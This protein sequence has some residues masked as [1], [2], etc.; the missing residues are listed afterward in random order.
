MPAEASGRAA[1]TH[2]SVEI[3]F[4]KM[5]AYLLRD[6]IAVRTGPNEIQYLED[7]LWAE[8]LDKSFQRALIAN[9]S[10]SFPAAEIQ[11]ADF[12][13]REHALEE[14][15]SP[16]P[17]HVGEPEGPK[18]MKIQVHVEQFDVDTTGHGQ[19][20]T[21]WRITN[22]DSNSLL[23]SGITSVTR[24]E[25]SARGDPKAV[26]KTMSL[27]TAEFSDKLAGSISELV[28]AGAISGSK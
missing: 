8:R 9:L 6:S 10:R 24:A 27:L 3:G 28:T 12:P 18:T 11:P 7:A 15:A 17:L 25:S 4:V 16:T 26:A 5:P 21:E 13:R 20:I 22:P 19:L 23:K 2:L 1:N 14:T